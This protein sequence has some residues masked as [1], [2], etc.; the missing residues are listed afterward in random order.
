MHTAGQEV[1]KHIERPSHAVP[2][3]Y[4]EPIM[5]LAERMSRMDRVPPGDVPYM[6]DQLADALHITD[7]RRQPWFRRM[8]D[9]AACEQ[10]DLETAK[11]GA[12]VVL[13]LV[14]KADTERSEEAAAYFTRMREKMGAEPIAVPADLA[15]HKDLALRYLT[16]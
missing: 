8:N 15:D 7:L 6:V 13:A 14:M 3:K 1:H 16:G 10:L 4:V 5:Y 11:K 9:D 2:R 12:L